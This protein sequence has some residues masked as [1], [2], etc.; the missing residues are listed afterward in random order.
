MHILQIVIFFKRRAAYIKRRHYQHM[1]YV[2]LSWNNITWYHMM[3]SEKVLMHNFEGHMLNVSIYH[4]LF[5]EITNILP[6]LPSAGTSLTKGPQ[7]C[8]R[9][10]W[11]LLQE[12]EGP[13][14]RCGWNEIG[15]GNRKHFVGFQPPRRVCSSCTSEWILKPIPMGPTIGSYPSVT[16]L[17]DYT[18][19]WLQLTA[20]SHMQRLP[21]ADD[22]RRWHRGRRHKTMTR[23]QRTAPRTAVATMPLLW[24]EVCASRW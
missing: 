13:Q 7:C 15:V 11:L 21:V 10:R 14:G 20:S 4:V 16:S 1:T 12:K 19:S 22:G 24:S 5:I 3:Y 8:H 6:V 17:Y 23:N 18:K 2:S 9:C